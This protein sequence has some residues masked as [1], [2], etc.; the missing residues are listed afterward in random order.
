MGACC[1]SSL[2]CQKPS[3]NS[4]LQRGKRLNPQY[5]IHWLRLMESLIT[6]AS[7]TSFI[8]LRIWRL[9]RCNMR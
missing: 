1:E 5:G 7:A 4:C 9:C 3:W 8:D 6:T 2:L